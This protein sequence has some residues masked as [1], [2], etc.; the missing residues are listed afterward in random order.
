MLKPDYSK[1]KRPLFVSLNEPA[2][3]DGIHLSP[4][5][6]GSTG[7]RLWK[8]CNAVVPIGKAQFV[9]Y[10]RRQVL[11]YGPRHEVLHHASDKLSELD[12]SGE[13]PVVW[14][15]NDLEAVIV[16]LEWRPFE[17]QENGV[18]FPHPRR[19]MHYLRDEDRAKAALFMADLMQPFIPARIEVLFR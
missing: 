13:G 2:Q 16:G 4:Y 6:E 5:V 15:I 8:M 11:T 10:S 1:D 19:R 7:W 18:V 17:K 3:Y 12:V 14:L 9:K